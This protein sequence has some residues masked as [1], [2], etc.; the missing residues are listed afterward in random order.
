MEPPG[1]EA[2]RANVLKGGPNRREP[3]T[4]VSAPQEFLHARLGSRVVRATLRERVFAHY[5]NDKTGVVGCFPTTLAILASWKCGRK[6]AAISGELQ[7][8]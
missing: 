6:P 2:R 1:S 8:I 5:L 7:T 3:K 4:S